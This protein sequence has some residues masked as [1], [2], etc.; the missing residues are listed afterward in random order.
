VY[1]F[2]LNRSAANVVSTNPRLRKSPS[3]SLSD[4]VKRPK[5]SL[6]DRFPS[7][8]AAVFGTPEF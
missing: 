3:A 8:I 1:G 4:S 2:D 5:N 6:N 7:G